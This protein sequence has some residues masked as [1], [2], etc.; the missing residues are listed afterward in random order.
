[1]KSTAKAQPGIQ[2]SRTLTAAGQQTQ[3][4]SYTLGTRQLVASTVCPEGTADVEVHVKEYTEFALGQLK[5]LKN[6][7]R[8]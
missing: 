6:S 4:L 2:C 8:D 1:M 5:H 3:S 7:A